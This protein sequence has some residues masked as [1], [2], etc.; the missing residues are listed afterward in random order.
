MTGFTKRGLSRRRWSPATSGPAGPSKAAS[1]SP[2]LPQ[3]VPPYPLPQVVPQPS[4]PLWSPSPITNLCA[5]L[6]VTYDAPASYIY[7]PGRYSQQL[8]FT[9][10][11]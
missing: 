1:D 9:Y 3:V 8:F 10:K 11:D 2:P 4:F 5:K 7:S 6:T